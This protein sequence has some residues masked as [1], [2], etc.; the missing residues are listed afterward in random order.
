MFHLRFRLLLY[1]SVLLAAPVR[2]GAQD[3]VFETFAIPYPPGSPSA[4]NGTEAIGINNHGAVVGY[5]E[6]AVITPWESLGAQFAFKRHAN[7]VLEYPIGNPEGGYIGGL[8]DLKLG[9]GGARALGINNLGATVGRWG[10]WAFLLANGRLTLFKTA[11]YSNIQSINDRGDYVGYN[12]LSG[13]F[14]RID[15]NLI[16]IRRTPGSPGGKIGSISAGLPGTGLLSAAPC[17]S[18]S[19]TTPA[20]ARPQRKADQGSR[21]REYRHVPHR[22]Q[23]RRRKDRGWYRQDGLVHSF[24]WN[25]VPDLSPVLMAEPDETVVVGVYTIKRT[26]IHEIAVPGAD[27]TRANSIN[28]TG[29]IAG[30]VEIGGAKKAFVAT[31]A[32]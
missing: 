19:A 28:A 2:L 8:G 7:G 32:P 25:Y 6:F 30:T 27:V 11:L 18:T 26:S 1:A 14:A 4:L 21:R 10:N 29:T 22:H 9:P 3:Y 15:G 17:C 31:S 5:Y 20:F 12:N 23:Q 16:E 24:V 13:S